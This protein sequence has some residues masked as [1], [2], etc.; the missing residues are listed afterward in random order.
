MLKQ[1]S[2]NFL[3]TAVF[4]L[5]RK[6][7]IIDLNDAAKNLF[8]GIAITLK[9]QHLFDIGVTNFQQKLLEELTQQSTGFI[10]N[11]QIQIGD[12]L[13]TGSLLLS[14]FRQS[15]EEFI[16]LELQTSQSHRQ[17]KKDNQLQQ[18]NR[19]GNHLI[20][21]LAHE[22]KNP[23]GGIK[24]AAQLM[25][26]KFA[27]AEQYC[28]IIIQESNRL[29]E[30]VS[31]LLLPAKQ[32]EKV[33]INI[34]QIIDQ[35][36]AILQLQ[37]D[38][39]IEIIKDYDPSLPE[40]LVCKDQIQQALINLIKNSAEA[41]EKAGKITLKTRIANIQTIGEHSYKSILQIDV[42]DNGCGI[43]DELIADIFF[44]TIS[45]KN[46]CGLGLS[47]AQSLV[48]RHQGIIQVK[49]NQQADNY[50]TCFSIYLPLQSQD[51]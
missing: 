27:E 45:S 41:I 6:A 16:L 42:I 12:R 36:I 31:R 38:N 22:I 37:I 20:L 18:Q 39:S 35:A 24:G 13:I 34:H 14:S 47:I 50:Q 15:D 2:L 7:R 43:P 8:S 26:R 33:L 21:A 32:E 30:L 9:G 46:T 5:D 48:Q 25:Q 40:I 19:V 29:D 28:R 49:S 3:A 17:I 10:E 23:L 44:P 51:E 1:L 11:A 4:L